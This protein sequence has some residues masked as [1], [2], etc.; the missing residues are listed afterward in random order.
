MKN[1]AIFRILSKIEKERY[2]ALFDEKY[3]IDY[4]NSQKG[5]KWVLLYDYDEESDKTRYFL[6][7]NLNETKL[8]SY[9]YEDELDDLGI[10]QVI[11]ARNKYELVE[12][13]KDYQLLFANGIKMSWGDIAYFSNY[14]EKLGKRFGCLTEFRENGII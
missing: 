3:I 6:Y 1:T 7:I 9:D 10:T 14:F 12:Q 8:D 2:I 4:L 11:Y 13:A 5:K